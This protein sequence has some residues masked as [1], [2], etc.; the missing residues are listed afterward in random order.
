MTAVKLNVNVN[1]W[2]C[3][4]YTEKIYNGIMKFFKMCPWKFRI[5]ETLQIS[6]YPEI[7]S[8]YPEVKKYDL[9]WRQSQP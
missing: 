2:V 4:L 7:V 5:L 3:H 6:L 1:L 8:L 9:N